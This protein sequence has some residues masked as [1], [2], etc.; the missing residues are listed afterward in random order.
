[1]A[2][3]PG[4]MDGKLKEVLL[5]TLLNDPS[6]PVRLKAVGILTQYASDP[7]VQEALL[8]S[9]GRDP[10]VQIRLLALE[11]LADRGVDPGAIRNAIGEVSEEG[12]RAVFQRAVELTGGL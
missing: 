4:S 2:M 11:C 9:L 6:L 10:S 1:M 3:A 12:D 7:A 5:F 8:L